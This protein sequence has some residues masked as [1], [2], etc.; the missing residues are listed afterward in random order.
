M[1]ED[2]DRKNAA[3]DVEIQILTNQNSLLIQHEH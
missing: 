1:Q 2:I 3:V